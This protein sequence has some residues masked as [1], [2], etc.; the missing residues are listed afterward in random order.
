MVKPDQAQSFAKKPKDRKKKAIVIAG[1]LLL[2]AGIGVAGWFSYPLIKKQLD[3]FTFNSLG[4]ESKSQRNGETYS[5]ARRSALDGSYESGQKLLDDELSIR[6]SNKD[7]ADIYDLKAM[8][9]YNEKQYE[10]SLEYA[11]K[12]DQLVPTSDSA[13]M[14]AK[15][16]EALGDRFNAVQYYEIFIDRFEPKNEIDE[17]TLEDVNLTIED[18]KR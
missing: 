7:I 13:Y 14:I 10:K 4:D 9:A 2:V 18:L 8:L 3:I 15:V 1:V 5:S 16:Y 6:T 17:T 12:V 11:M